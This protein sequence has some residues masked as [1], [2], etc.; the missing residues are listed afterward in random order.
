MQKGHA[1]LTVMLI[2]SKSYTTSLYWLFTLPRDFL[3]LMLFACLWFAAPSF[4]HESTLPLNSPSFFFFAVTSSGYARIIPTSRSQPRIA[5]LPAGSLPSFTAL[6]LPHYGPG[7]N[8]PSARGLHQWNLP[9]MISTRSCAAP[10]SDPC[11]PPSLP[12]LHHFDVA[13]SRLYHNVL[14]RQ[15]SEPLLLPSFA[16][17]L[18]TFQ[19]FLCACT[20]PSLLLAPFSLM[21]TCVLWI[22]I[23]IVAGRS[24]SQCQN[25]ELKKIQPSSPDLLSPLNCS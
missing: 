21:D 5:H 3:E 16:D 10:L 15:S 19:F 6:T 7:Q 24:Q 1:I 12:L 11:P 4:V 20:P 17:Q 14:V 13:I 23:L 9:K 2:F 18:W 25:Q 8:P 22:W